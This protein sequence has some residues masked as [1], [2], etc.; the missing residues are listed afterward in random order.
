VGPINH[1]LDA[2]IG[3]QGFEITE[4]AGNSALPA[5]RL[6][7]A[8]RRM[9]RATVRYARAGPQGRQVNLFRQTQPRHPRL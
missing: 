8:V 9:Q 5:R 1:S 3:E 4:S 2:R 7:R 6:K